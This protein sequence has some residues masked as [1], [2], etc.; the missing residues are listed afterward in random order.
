MKVSIITTCFNCETTIEKTINS[1]L[2]QDYNDIEYIMIDGG[3]NDKTLEIINKYR[4][5]ITTIVSE[6]DDGIYD[7]IN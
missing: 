6:N 1:V 3:S 2:S 5:K 4:T 7:G